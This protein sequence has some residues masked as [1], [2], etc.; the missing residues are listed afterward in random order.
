MATVLV[1]EGWHSKTPDSGRLMELTNGNGVFEI[2][3]RADASD[4]AAVYRIGA[5]ILNKA[6]EKTKPPADILN[7][8]LDDGCQVAAKVHFVKTK[9]GAD[10]VVFVGGISM[11]RADL[12]I[13]GFTDPGR[14]NDLKAVGSMFLSVK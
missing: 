7:T 11:A 13:L 12:L 2:Q 5:D 9:D 6:L 4:A 14:N 3:T 10:V 8:S 1:E